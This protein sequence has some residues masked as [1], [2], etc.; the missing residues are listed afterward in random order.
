VN[1]D[2]NSNSKQRRCLNFCETPVYREALDAAKWL[3]S[4]TSRA[5]GAGELLACCKA[6]T[7]PLVERFE[8]VGNDSVYL[9]KVGEELLVLEHDDWASPRA[10]T[11]ASLD[12][13][14]CYAMHGTHTRLRSL[15]RVALPSPFSDTNR[16]RTSAVSTWLTQ[17]AAVAALRND[18]V[19]TR[20]CWTGALARWLSAEFERRYRFVAWR[21]V[22]L[23]PNRFVKLELRK[24]NR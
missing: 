19:V 5:V 9:N 11:F 22:G 18:P 14:V 10:I 24:T 23:V 2:S 7:V 1:S 21:T 12:Q 15:P 20:C 3:R 13:R 16:E 6:A 4:R 8:A 17:S